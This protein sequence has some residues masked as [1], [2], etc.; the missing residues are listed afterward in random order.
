MLDTAGIL[1]STVMMMVVIVQAVRLDR[2]QAW[3][4]AIKPKDQPGLQRRPWNR[5]R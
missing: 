5:D 1:L 4:Q 3:F 2:V